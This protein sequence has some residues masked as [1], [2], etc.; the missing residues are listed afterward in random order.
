MRQWP[1]III[2]MSGSG[3]LPSQQC[4]ADMLLN[5]GVEESC[6]GCANGTCTIRSDIVNL[7]SQLGASSPSMLRTRKSSHKALYY[8][9]GNRFTH[10]MSSVLRRNISNTLFLF[11]IIITI[12]VTQFQCLLDLGVAANPM[13][14]ALGGNG[15]IGSG[16]MVGAGGALS[17]QQQQQQPPQP[18]P[19]EAEIKV[20]VDINRK[21]YLER[22]YKKFRALG[23]NCSKQNIFIFAN[24]EYF[25][26]EQHALLETA[27]FHY[28]DA[29]IFVIGLQDDSFSAYN[30]EGYYYCDLN[31]FTNV[32][33]IVSE[34]ILAILILDGIRCYFQIVFLKFSL[35]T[36]KVHWTGIASRVFRCSGLKF[37]W[38]FLLL[39]LNSTTTSQQLRISL[40][41]S[42]VRL[43]RMGLCPL[44]GT[45]LCLRCSTFMVV[46]TFQP[47]GCSWDRS[48]SFSKV[49]FIRFLFYSDTIS[50][51]C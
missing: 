5:G 46:C 1:T 10:K 26:V 18:E 44:L 36:N 19:T 29:N 16:G 28:P 40:C 38:L 45:C 2:I 21:N 48:T 30:K 39:V 43:I 25:L 31:T 9:A 7:D 20:E 8:N 14:G 17:A 27:L 47:M 41:S 6:G 35:K 51:Y 42:E 37:R 33:S 49:Y 3:H 50:Q 11:T 23:L 13:G 4:T 12:S 34:I 24:A 32:Q 22:Y 15:I